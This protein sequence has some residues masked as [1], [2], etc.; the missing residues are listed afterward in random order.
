MPPTTLE[1]LRTAKLEIAPAESR[2]IALRT[3]MLGVIEGMTKY[4]F[5]NDAGVQVVGNK[6]HKLSDAI[7]EV[8]REYR[9]AK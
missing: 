7:S 5:F 2:N 3:R 8:E 9:L 1:N 6:G 4:A